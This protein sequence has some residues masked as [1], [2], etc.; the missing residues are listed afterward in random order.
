MSS[1]GNELGGPEKAQ[2]MLKAQGTSFILK[3][4]E[5]MFRRPVKYPDTVSDISCLTCSE[6][7]NVIAFD[8]IPA[9]YSLG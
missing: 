5:V 6:F 8:R 7:N 3:S 2:A 4:I 9:C 1:L